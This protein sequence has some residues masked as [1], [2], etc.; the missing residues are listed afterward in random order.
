MTTGTEGGM[1]SITVRAPAEALWAMVT[2][3]TRTGEWSPEATGGAWIDGATGPAVGARFKGT[4][5]RGR[6]RWATTCEVTAS[7]PGREFT[8]VT[9]RPG[10]PET[11]WRYVFEPDG[12]GGTRVTESFQLVKPLGAVSNL[13][14]RVTT[15]VKDRRADLEAN[16]RV[17]LARLKAIAEP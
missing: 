9:G 11:V 1:A 10:K 8:F 2:D 17:S 14:T 4:N 5:R 3:V 7:A 16:I 12:D 6:T 15:G 13:V